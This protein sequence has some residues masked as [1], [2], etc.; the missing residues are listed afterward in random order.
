MELSLEHTESDDIESHVHCPGSYPFNVVKIIATAVVLSVWMG[1]GSCLCP[2]SNDVESHI[3]CS[4]SYL[5]DVVKNNS[6]GCGIVCSDGR[7]RL[8]VSQIQ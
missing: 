2:K 8:F 7:W 6:D 1:V 5:F 3:H 4:G